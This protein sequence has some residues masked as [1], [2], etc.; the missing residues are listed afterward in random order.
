MKIAVDLLWVKH[1]R[2]GGIESY[3]LNLLNG[4]RRIDHDN[5]YILI[6]SNDNEH[7]FE[8]YTKFDNFSLYRCNVQSMKVMKTVIWENLHLDNV[9]TKLHADF[10]FVPYYR[11]PCLKAKNRYIIVL[12]DMQSLHF[13]EYF[14][15]WKCLWLK[16]YWRLSLHSANQI[17]AISKFIK[18]DI[19]DW[20][21][22]DY[23]KISVIY[24]PILVTPERDKTTTLTKYRLTENGYFYTISSLLKHKNLI[25]ILKAIK[26]LKEKGESPH[27]VITGVKGSFTNEVSYFIKDNNLQDNCIYTGY[28]TD[29]EKFD[30]LRGCKLFLFP[31]VFE[32]FGMPPIESMLVGKNVITTRCASIP[33]VT[34]DKAI[35][36]EDPFDANE[37]ADK[38]GQKFPP[39]SEEIKTHMHNKYT[40]TSVAKQYLDL[41]EKINLLSR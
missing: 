28:I 40:P 30:L 14:P 20:Y 3:V 21:N 17:I 25:T 23:N 15:K 41:F 33:E 38:M 18:K 39:I 19:M 22:V 13:P 34:E 31:S 7:V 5:E 32:G 26:I 11:K 16:F 37:W 24:N 29:E 12:H 4:L 1:G 10:C 8:E 2:V 6:V 27:L 36:V 9:V 35:Y